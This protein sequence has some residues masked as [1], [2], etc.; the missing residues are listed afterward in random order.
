MNCRD[1]VKGKERRRREE[2]RIEIRQR[3]SKDEL[4]QNRKRGKH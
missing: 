3:I 2:L 1:K 4:R